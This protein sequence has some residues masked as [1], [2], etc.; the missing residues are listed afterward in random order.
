MIFEH[1]VLLEDDLSVWLPCSSLFVRVCNLFPHV[2]LYSVVVGS[3]MSPGDVALRST[4][5]VKGMLAFRWVVGFG[6]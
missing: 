5:E 6:A 3:A 1:E 4:E 2:F